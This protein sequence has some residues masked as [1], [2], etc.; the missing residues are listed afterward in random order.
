MNELT[1]LESAIL[2]ISKGHTPE[3]LKITRLEAFRYY[4]M[5]DYLA[6]SCSDRELVYIHFS[7]M[8]HLLYKIYPKKF[9]DLMYELI[10]SD[11]N[12]EDYS[13][14]EHIYKDKPKH[15]ERIFYS[16]LSQISTCL[17]YEDGKCLFDFK[18]EPD[19]LKEIIL[20]NYNVEVTKNN[21]KWCGN[22]KTVCIN[23]GNIMIDRW[24]HCKKWS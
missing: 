1:K 2:L 11:L 5:E 16:Y 14:I 12:P 19:E 22:C 4:L 13:Q 10:T 3:E 9:V 7:E 18:L 21:Y 15:Y 24:F 6:E 17:V 23:A 20:K 8:H